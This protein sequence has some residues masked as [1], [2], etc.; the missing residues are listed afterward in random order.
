MGLL[1]RRRNVLDELTSELAKLGARKDLLAKQL[2]TVEG[3][4]AEAVSA[5]AT[6]LLEGDLD[7]PSG[8][9]VIIERL[10]DE[11]SAVVDALAA[12]DA[13][14]MDAQASVDREQ[15]RI[16]R[17]TGTKELA[18]VVE[19]LTHVHDQLA[20]VAAKVAPAIA[21]VLAKLPAPHPVA[22]ERVKA[23][24]D[25]VLEAVQTVVS[26]ARSHTG[27]LISGD[28]QVVREVSEPVM[29]PAPKVERL[30]IFRLQ[31][32]KWLEADGSIRTVGAHVTCDPP[33][34]VARA[35]LANGNA[36]DP[37][38]DNAITLR[39]RVPPCYANYA[40]EDCI[41]LTTPKPIKPLGTPTAAAPVFH[42][43]FTPA[44]G[45][46]A[47]VGRNSR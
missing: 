41:D 18:A 23:F 9:P 16:C 15:D 17:E 44:R 5:R 42:S 27:R 24:L 31:A 2:A 10:R 14:V 29:P 28:A 46:F 43:E 40:A 12:I 34:E 39:T 32:S 13:K 8:E 4:I 38:C 22:P 19:D 21:A 26:E 30:E 45:G 3:K 47:T 25:G 6:H 33:I 36:I 11:K 7:V 20:A 1:S 37:L 35:A